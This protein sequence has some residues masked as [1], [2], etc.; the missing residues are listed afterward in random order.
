[1]LVVTWQYQTTMDLPTLIR[2]TM[3]VISSRT[4]A[5]V[6]IGRV[7]IRY[8]GLMKSLNG[9]IIR[10]VKRASEMNGI[11]IKSRERLI[12]A[13]ESAQNRGE[14]R[15]SCR[16]KPSDRIWRFPNMYK[17]FWHLTDKMLKPVRGAILAHDKTML[18]LIWALLRAGPAVALGWY[19][20]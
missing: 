4:S 6:S 16:F 10:E 19:D 14:V 20:R 13:R 1:M 17:C 11:L 7:I 18:G 2:T 3:S 12:C 15:T 9:S 8:A 5:A